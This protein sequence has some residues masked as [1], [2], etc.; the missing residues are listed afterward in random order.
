MVS[1][2]ET[3]M[4]WVLSE[5]LKLKIEKVKIFIFHSQNFHSQN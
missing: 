1:T 4:Y 2:S 5:L 3:V